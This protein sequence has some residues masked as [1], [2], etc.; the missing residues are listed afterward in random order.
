V[1]SPRSRPHDAGKKEAGAPQNPG[2][3]NLR[4]RKRSNY[5][6]FEV[7]FAAFLAGFLAAFFFAI[8]VYLLLLDFWTRGSIGLVIRVSY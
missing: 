4:N 2:V 3:T 7:F 6:F 1:S 5:F 8:M